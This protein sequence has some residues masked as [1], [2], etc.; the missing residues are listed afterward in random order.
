MVR[1]LT[2]FSRL[3]LVAVFVAFSSVSLGAQEH[4]F[5]QV[6]LTEAQVASY[7]KAH[8]ELRSV[9]DKIDK[10]GEQ[11]DPKLIGELEALAKKHGFE[12]FDQLDNVAATVSFMVGGFDFET[13]AFSEPRKV[14][15]DEVAAL[16]EDK[17]MPAEERTAL[18]KELEEAIATTPDVAHKSNIPIVKKYLKQL[19]KIN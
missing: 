8:S 7:L 2:Q 15:Q 13:G 3:L 9:M 18:I 1:Q 16:K 6:R 17:T 12:S 5:K 19:E 11:P 14:M 4:E 10:A